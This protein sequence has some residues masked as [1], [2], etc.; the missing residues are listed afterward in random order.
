M[1]NLLRLHDTMVVRMGNADLG[2]AAFLLQMTLF[3]SIY[4]KND[5]V[6]RWCIQTSGCLHGN[7]IFQCQNGD[8]LL[9]DDFSG[10]TTS[11]NEHEFDSVPLR[12]GVVFV[13]C[14]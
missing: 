5:V 11:S 9:R 13:L 1:S 3:V 8:V 2:K 4:S 12:I 10:D 14:A 7:E 6:L